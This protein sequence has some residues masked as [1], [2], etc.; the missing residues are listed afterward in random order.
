MTTE[1]QRFHRKR[2]RRP[3][4]FAGNITSGD[5]SLFDSK[6]WLPIPAIQ[7]KHSSRFS[8]NRNRRDC[9]AILFNIDQDRGGFKIIIPG[10]MV[11]GLKVPNQFS[12][13]RVECDQ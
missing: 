10:I 9:L 13:V 7:D 12:S 6:D 1:G 2:L 5:W 8:N 4:C 3:L 11:N